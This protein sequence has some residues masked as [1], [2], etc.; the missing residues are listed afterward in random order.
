MPASQHRRTYAF[1]TAVVVLAAGFVL[2]GAPAASAVTQNGPNNF[3]GPA[4]MCPGPGWNCTTATTDV[5]QVTTGGQNVFHCGAASCEVVQQASSGTNRVTC[6]QAGTANGTT[7]CTFDQDNQSGPNIANVSQTDTLTSGN[8]TAALGQTSTQRVTGTQHNV[9]GTNALDLAQRMTYSATGFLTVD[10]TQ[11]AFQLATIEQLSDSGDQTANLD[12]AQSLAQNGTGVLGTTQRQNTGGSGPNNSIE[13]DQKSQSGDN[14][15]GVKQEETLNQGAT[16]IL[17]NVTQLQGRTGGGE[18]FVWDV[19]SVDGTSHVDTEQLKIWTQNAV[20][21]VIPA[22]GTKT[23]RQLDGLRILGLPFTTHTSQSVQRTVLESDP[24]AQQVCIQNADIVNKINGTARQNCTVHDSEGE[25]EVRE[26]TTSGTEIQATNVCTSGECSAP[27][28]SQSSMHKAV[29]NVSDEQ[30][31]AGDESPSST[32]A[33]P[34]ETIEYQLTYEND[35]AA[36]GQASGVVVT[37]QLPPDTTFLGCSDNCSQSEGGTLSWQVGNVNPG[38]RAVRTFRVAVNEGTSAETNI[39]NTAVADS[40]QE[41]PVNSNSTTV[42]VTE[43]EPT[44]G[45]LSGTVTDSSTSQPIAGATVQAGESSTTTD[46]AGAY[47]LTDLAPGSYS[48]TASKAGY[49]PVT[50]SGVAV[51][52]GETTT[53]NFSLTPVPTTGTIS[54][55]VRDSSNNQP[56]SG[57]TVAIDQTH[58]TTTDAQG[59]YSLTAVPP[60]SYSVTASRSGYSPVT[61]SGVSVTAGQTTTRDFSLT[62]VPTTG[63]ISGTVRD[64]TNA[65]P[66]AGATVTLDGGA[67]RTTLADGSYSFANVAAGSHTLSAARN[68][69]VSDEKPA[70][71]TAGETTTV[72][73]SLSPV[74]AP[75]QYRIVLEWGSQPSDLDAHLWLPSGTPYHVYYDRKGSTN[76]CPNARLDIDDTTGGGPETVTIVDPFDGS[77][78]YAVHKYAGSNASLTSSQAVVKLYKGDALVQTFNVPSGGPNGHNWWHVFDLD[79]ATGAVTTA[80]QLLAGPTGNAGNNTQPPAPYADTGSGCVGAQSVDDGSSSK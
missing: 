3:A 9:D 76:N 52:A 61:H 26:T 31:F 43:P 11:D 35:E 62:P 48:V 53:R 23:Q 2:G 6:D 79:G 80:N 50:H 51:T 39:P 71:V 25:P 33:Q 72:D 18:H 75:D 65:N 27:P 16:P 64:A 56:I 74:Q 49:T 73:F 42:D 41:E 55:T 30:A 17:G 46:A 60:G 24:G 70:S 68:G 67:T 14:Q 63:A 10:L 15:L 5:V 77:Y 40:D 37:D 45:T 36:P 22:G 21:P 7:S 54:G 29:R 69:Y 44:T 38:G 78:R 4:T 59:G 32:T 20:A 34:G 57:A 13:I 58:T 47:S 28:Q 66:I 19:N 1:L 8:A 12:Q